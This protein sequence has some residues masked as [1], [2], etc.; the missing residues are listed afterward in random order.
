MSRFRQILKYTDQLPWSD[1]I[2]P[3]DSMLIIFD[4][5][6]KAWKELLL[7]KGFYIFDTCK[8]VDII[9]HM[10]QSAVIATSNDK[11]SKQ[12]NK[13]KSDNVK[14]GGRG[15]RSNRNK[16]KRE[17][18]GFGGIGRGGG[19]GQGGY[20]HNNNGGRGRGN[21]NGGRGC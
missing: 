16:E 8:L 1:T 13:K 7:N 5:F 2:Q 15:W 4:L 6:S 14:H 21:Y 3:F 12:D 17:N 18:G 10:D 9:Q 11:K 19:R 20:N